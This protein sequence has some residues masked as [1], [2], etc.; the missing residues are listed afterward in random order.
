MEHVCCIEH[1]VALRAA[2]GYVADARVC[3][4]LSSSGL[5]LLLLFPEPRAPVAV[6]ASPAVLSL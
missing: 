6:P 5:S 3:R 2:A 4:A 1:S